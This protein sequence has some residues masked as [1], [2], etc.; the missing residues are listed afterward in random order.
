MPVIPVPSEWPTLE[1]AEWEETRRTLHMYTQMVG[2]IRLA[3]SPPRPGWLGCPLHLTARGLTTGPMPWGTAAIEIVLNFVD[4][5]LVVLATDGWIRQIPLTPAR[6]VADMYAEIVRALNDLGVDVEIWTRPQEVSDT[7]PFDEN[8]HDCSYDPA[9]VRTFFKILT[10]VHAVFDEW[11]STF[12]GRSSLQ[13]WWGAFDLSTARFTGKRL[14]PPADAGHIMRWDLDTEH[15]SAGWWPGDERFPDPAFYAYAYPMPDGVE[16]VPVSPAAAWSA[17]LGEWI[18]RYEDARA[19]G[20]VRSAILEFLDGAWN[21]VGTASGWDLES[22][23]YEP[24]P[25]SPAR[26]EDAS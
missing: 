24:P 13:F 1:Y 16:S 4:H 3:L 18:L 21:A 2:K 22:F 10:G 8:Q 6:S 14:E 17:E 12:F 11:Q 25:P 15:F 20:D 26:A 19:T 5:R 23:R 9:A 7:T